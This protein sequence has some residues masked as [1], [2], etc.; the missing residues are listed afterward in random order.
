MSQTENYTD[1]KRFPKEQEGFVKAIGVPEGHIPRCATYPLVRNINVSYFGGR[2]GGIGDPHE[3]TNTDRIEW[4]TSPAESGETTVFTWIGA[5]Q[6]W[7]YKPSYPYSKAVLY[8]GGEEVCKFP[9]G[10][11]DSFRIDEKDFKFVFD[12]KRFTSN[13]EDHQRTMDVPGISGFY[14]LEV[15]PR[16]I[17]RGE[18][19]RIKVRVEPSTPKYEAAYFI[20]PRTDALSFNLSILRDEMEQLQSDMTSL[21]KTVEILYAQCYPQFF[22][23]KMKGRRFLIHTD[24]VKHYIVPNVTVMSDG[25]IIVTSRLGMDHADPYSTMMMYRSADGGET[26]K[27]E[28]LFERQGEVVDHRCSPLFELPG[29][30]WIITDYRLGS[31]WYRG[32][33]RIF[34]RGEGSVEPTLWVARSSDKGKTWAFTDKPLSVPGYKIEYAE[35]ERKMIMTGTGKLLVPAIFSPGEY[36]SMAA[37]IF[38]S[39]DMGCTWR[40]HAQ[41]GDWE[42]YG[43][44]MTIL[45]TN[46]GKLLMAGR[47]EGV[48]GQPGWQD[49][50]GLWLYESHD[51]GKTWSKPVQSGMSSIRSPGHLMQLKD[52]RILCTHASRQH[53]GSIYITT[54]GDDGKTWDTENTRIVTDDIVQWDACYP[55]SDQ[56]RDGKIITVW[57]GNN[58]GKFHLSGMVYEPEDI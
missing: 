29:G 19:V 1:Y 58:F 27:Q 39:D 18:P 8:V 55:C 9:L 3:L 2:A 4:E 28:V 11:P 40:V 23:Q 49:K 20:V 42:E 53:P 52:G 51:E 33:K 45:Q 35:V 17:T 46:S 21:K 36:N 34:T 43:V 48:N 38:A 12:C 14:R 13:I 57:Y 37:V 25:E 5:S 26:W 54:S 31:D 44:E 56:M 24:E 50:G 30:D 32:E 41:L 6:V 22:P 15:P 7:P 47:C 10:R 16:C